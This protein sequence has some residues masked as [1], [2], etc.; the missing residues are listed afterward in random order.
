MNMSQVAVFHGSGQPL[1]LETVPIPPIR[2]GEILVR[3]EYT[4]LCRSDLNTFIGKRTEKT[5][6]ILGHEIVGTI[7]SLGPKAPSHDCRGAELRVGDRITWAIYASDPASRMARL[8]FPQKALDLFKYGHEELRAD[9]TLHGGLAEHCV[10]RRHTPVVRLEESLPLPLAALIN[11]SVATVAGSLRLAGEIRDRVV[12]VAGV[13]MLGIIACAMCRCAGARS[14]IAIDIDGDRLGTAQEMGA[15][16]GVNLSLG[17]T[18]VQEQLAGDRQGEPALV[19]LDYSGVP[20]TMETLLS[21]LGV[22]GTAVFVGATFPQRA[23]RVNAEQLIRKMHTIRGLHNYG[24]QDLVTAVGFMEEQHG[25]FPLLGL[26]HDG[27]LLTEANE[28]FAF[29][30]NSRAHRVGIRLGGCRG[31]A[32]RRTMNDNR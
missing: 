8:G 23:L 16:S 1:T 27:F 25:R 26:V 30:L 14:I 4:T 12:L 13:G 15:D 24:E 21:L 9:Q 5:P 7:E 19:A 17:G 31:A 2:E 20:D 18:P 28:A 11:C 3:N 6:T 22:G 10:I 32:S 29:A